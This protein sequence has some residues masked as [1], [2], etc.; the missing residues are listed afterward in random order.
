MT[1]TM[2]VT[3][4]YDTEADAL[5]AAACDLDRLHRTMGS[6]IDYRG[7]PGGKLFEGLTYDYSPVLWTFVR[8]PDT[9]MTCTRVDPVARVLQQRQIAPVA[10][11]V[12][13]TI[14]ASE[15]GSLWTDRYDHHGPEGNA[16]LRWLT[17]HIHRAY[18]RRGGGRV[19]AISFL[20]T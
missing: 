1:T 13:A 3:A 14:A 19:A 16:L 17:R 20:E 6:L 12:T 8:L 7:M 2:I 11:T 15:V 5:F 4:L 9:R 18:H 10:M